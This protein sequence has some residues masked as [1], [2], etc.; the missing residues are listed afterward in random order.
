MTIGSINN[1]NLS[2]S[3]P[4]EALQAFGRNENNSD[5]SRNFTRKP[6]SSLGNVDTGERTVGS[7]KT[8][9]TCTLNAG[10]SNTMKYSGSSASFPKSTSTP[11]SGVSSGC[12]PKSVG[13]SFPPPKRIALDSSTA[14]VP[15]NVSGDPPV[16]LSA[17]S[18][19]L[20]PGFNNASSSSQTGEA[21]RF[22]G[23]NQVSHGDSYTR[24]PVNVQGF[25]GGAVNQRLH[26]C[27]SA[28]RNANVQSTVTSAC[29]QRSD[30]LRPSHS[31]ENPAAGYLHN[32]PN[33]Q[34]NMRPLNRTI[35][36]SFENNEK[37]LVSANY[38]KTVNKNLQKQQSPPCLS[39]NLQQR[40]RFS[41]LSPPN[42]SGNS[43]S[44]E[45]TPQGS[46]LKAGISVR[47]GSG[48]RDQSPFLN[49]ALQTR[50]NDKGSPLLSKNTP[51]R[52]CFVTP[53]SAQTTRTRKFPGPA[54][55][56]PKL[57]SY[58]FLQV[59]A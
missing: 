25:A 11:T 43:N 6:F 14:K 13:T 16:S 54:G 34:H 28:Q 50:G 17:R 12:A 19:S 40:S 27:A 9:T 21:H 10:S 32:N 4:K 41:F 51:N 47:S 20:V 1:G 55:L 33:N 58:L 26:G 2:N 59:V 42:A 49:T 8:S 44:R 53:P 38:S 46:V 56:L 31:V 37:C 57:V 48:H 45:K 23:G 36:S 5:R 15:G 3:K 29:R 30:Q 39:G 24:K 52:E 22:V 18:S 35:H 7:H